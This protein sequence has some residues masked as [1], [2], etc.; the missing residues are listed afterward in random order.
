MVVGVGVKCITWDLP[1][2]VWAGVRFQVR[3]HRMKIGTR[4]EGHA[5]GQWPCPEMMRAG[6]A[7]RGSPAAAGRDAS[8]LEGGRRWPELKSRC[9]GA[10]LQVQWLQRIVRSRFPRFFLKPRCR[11]PASTAG[12]Q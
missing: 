9:V 8:L 2:Q 10:M 4:P 1:V 7:R 11:F 5:E 3:H 12:P 6:L